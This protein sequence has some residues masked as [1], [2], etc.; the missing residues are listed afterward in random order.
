MST[1]AATRPTHRLW[2]PLLVLIAAPLA[3]AAVWYWPSSWEHGN[4]FMALLGL[5]LGSAVVLGFWMLFL[6]RFPK[7]VRLGTVA[8]VVLGVGLFF[9][10]CVREVHFRGDMV[11]VFTFRWE[12]TQD[13]L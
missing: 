7:A 5:A 11:P 4:R 3:G 1:A 2:L 9:T 12:K 6:S 10:V 13:D 8:V